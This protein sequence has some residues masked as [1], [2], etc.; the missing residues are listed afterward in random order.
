[1][2]RI[3][4][5]GRGRGGGRRWRRAAL[6]GKSQ[7][8]EVGVRMYVRGGYGSGELVGASIARASCGRTSTLLR[9]PL[10]RD[11]RVEYVT[12]VIQV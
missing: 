8:C 7:V 1:V 10:P 6:V 3:W 5:R 4:E 12:K 9:V 11:S 2:E